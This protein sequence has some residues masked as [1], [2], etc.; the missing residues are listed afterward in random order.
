MLKGF[1]LYTFRVAAVFIGLLPS[2]VL[3]D[4]N[5]RLRVLCHNAGSS[6]K[7]IMF[8]L[9]QTDASEISGSAFIRVGMR[10][11]KTTQKI[12]FEIRHYE[13]DGDLELADGKTVEGFAAEL[14]ETQPLRSFE[15]LADHWFKEIAFSTNARQTNAGFEDRPMMELLIDWNKEGFLSY[16]ESPN[17]WAGRCEPPIFVP[18]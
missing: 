13:F 16:V 18:G 10:T 15:G 6:S 12:P 17:L 5:N 7:P 2:L 9:D 3:A 1:V 14:S 11:N 4:G 8:I